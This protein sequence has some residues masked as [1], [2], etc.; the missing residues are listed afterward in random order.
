MFNTTVTEPQPS[1]EAST[2]RRSIS[3]QR[4]IAH[5]YN[6]VPIQPAQPSLDTSREVRCL[7]VV[8]PDTVPGCTACV[9]VLF[10]VPDFASVN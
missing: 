1:S 6:D 8:N 3:A 5:R 2:A 7:L 10:P 4:C 9:L